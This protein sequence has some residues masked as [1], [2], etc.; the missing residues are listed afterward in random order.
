LVALI[1]LTIRVEGKG[2]RR[3]DEPGT[4]LIPHKHQNFPSRL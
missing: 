3:N 2:V 4:E 1:Q